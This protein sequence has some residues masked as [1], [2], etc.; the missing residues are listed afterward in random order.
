MPELTKI[1]NSKRSDRDK[2]LCYKPQMTDYKVTYTA[3]A[4][5]VKP[6]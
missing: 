6:K 5:H 1:Q 4:V 3:P 2:E